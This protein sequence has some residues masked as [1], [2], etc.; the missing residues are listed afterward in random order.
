MRRHRRRSRS[1]DLGLET[2]KLLQ[3]HI[4]AEDE[5]ARV[6]EITVFNEGS[7][8][9]FVGFLHETLDPPHMGVER[10]RRARMNV[11]VAGGWMVGR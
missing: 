7:G 6:P 1:R 9:R 5:I 4:G 11:A 10:Q 8:M 3:H 2:L